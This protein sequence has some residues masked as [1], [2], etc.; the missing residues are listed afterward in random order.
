VASH[1]N[2]MRFLPVMRIVTEGLK[3]CFGELP[4]CDENCPCRPQVQV[5]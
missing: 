5:W 4:I 1:S 2:Q 3:F